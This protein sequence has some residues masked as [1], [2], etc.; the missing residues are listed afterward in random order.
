MDYYYPYHFC[1]YHLRI[2]N[3]GFP[4]Q[5]LPKIIQISVIG[6]IIITY[7]RIEKPT[8]ENTYLTLI[9]TCV[10]GMS[11]NGITFENRPWTMSVIY[12]N[13]TVKFINRLMVAT[14]KRHYFHIDITK[15]HSTVT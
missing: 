1:L 15:R 7:A 11:S 13:G 12:R 4:S 5:N 6:F 10:Y 3:I 14:N 2:G 8:Q 9:L